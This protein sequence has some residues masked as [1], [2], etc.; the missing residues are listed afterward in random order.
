MSHELVETPVTVMPGTLSRLSSWI[1]INGR[2]A[3]IEV[4]VNFAAPFLIYSAAHAWLGD[5]GAMIAASASP[6]G[7]S[8]AEFL[9]RRAVDALSL[10]VLTGI[11]PGVTDPSAFRPSHQYA[12]AGRR[13]L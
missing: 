12:R 9:R 7:W 5:V 11:V 8:I 1:R 4:V 2:R 13:G 6:L 10:L 3:A